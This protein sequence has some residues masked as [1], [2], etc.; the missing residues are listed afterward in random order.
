MVL[1][2]AKI[3]PPAN[4]RQSSAVRATR[5]ARIV[6]SANLRRPPPALARSA[7]PPAKQPQQL[8]PRQWLI[9]RSAW[10][11]NLP[12]PDVNLPVSLAANR[13]QPHL[14]ISVRP[15]PLLQPGQHVPPVTFAQGARH[16]HSCAPPAQGGV[17][18]TRMA[19]SVSTTLH[20]SRCCGITPAIT[21][22]VCATRGSALKTGEL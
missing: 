8:V 5:H 3:A 20:I 7:L 12:L 22:I 14:E 18:V 11:A 13:V 21:Q 9:A 19:P 10:P 1:L 4:I 17:M 2:D 16:F 15:G 6:M